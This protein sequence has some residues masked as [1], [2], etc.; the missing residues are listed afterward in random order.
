MK[1]EILGINRSKTSATKTRIEMMGTGEHHGGLISD[2]G[3][4]TF[5]HGTNKIS[6]ASLDLLVRP[7]SGTICFG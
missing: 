4:S 3:G 1:F 7:P 5:G 6:P 2:M